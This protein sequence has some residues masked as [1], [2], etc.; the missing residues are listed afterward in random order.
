M[1]VKV[2]AAPGERAGAEISWSLVRKM[3]EGIDW[4]RGLVVTRDFGRAPGTTM[5]TV[6]VLAIS[7]NV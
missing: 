6:L 2:G 1:V 5:S 7:E 3:V 4:S